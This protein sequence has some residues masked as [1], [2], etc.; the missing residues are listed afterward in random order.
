MFPRERLSIWC[1]LGVLAGIN[2]FGIPAAQGQ[3]D[4]SEVHIQPRG[5]MSPVNTAT[6]DE[7]NLHAAQIRKN[8]DLVLVPVTLTDDMGRVVT[9]LGQDN[10]KVFEG[11][12]LQEIKH[13]S[14]EDS[15]VSLG[16]ILDLS[17]SMESKIDRAREAVM[18][19]LKSSNPQ[20]EF[21][22][23]TFSD[24][25]RLMQ[26][27]TQ[28]IE[29]MQEKLLFAT[30]KGRTSLLDAIYT[31]IQ[32]M[33][34][35]KYQKK[36]LL[37]ISDGGDNHSLYTE[38]EVKSVVKEADV[39]IYSVGVFDHDCRT[40]TEQQFGHSRIG[41][42]QDCVTTEERLGPALL[43]DVSEVTGGRSYTL[44]NPN[45]LP[46]ITEHIGYELR[47]QYVLGYRPTCKTEDGKWRKIKVKLASLPKGLPPLR[48][49]SKTG[50]YAP[51]R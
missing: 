7:R 46:Q 48:V 33:K 6:G 32:K 30:P 2:W 28:K 37:V 21:F 20:D 12:Q 16:V 27:F 34:E 25:P 40:A 51:S 39:L 44:D 24:A 45:E 36:A 19:M 18:E 1:C 41:F 31:G 10:F 43:K 14:M 11:K 22:L 9:G 38:N 29:N 8:V 47:N 3:G 49:R 13:F 4:T 42:D 15:P 35:A 5:Q 17:G 50:Y 26:D 23:I